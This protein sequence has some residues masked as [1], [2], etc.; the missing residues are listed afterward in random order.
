MKSDDAALAQRAA[1]MTVTSGDLDASGTIAFAAH[2][3]TGAIVVAGVGVHSIRLRLE[4]ARTSDGAAVAEAM[5]VSA[6]VDRERRS[7]ALPAGFA[8]ALRARLAPRD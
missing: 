6:C 1:R 5:L 4:V 2:K 8:D 7:T 3:L